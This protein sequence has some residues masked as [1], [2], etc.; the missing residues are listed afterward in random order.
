MSAEEE[1]VS[2]L[3]GM[4]VETLVAEFE[5]ADISGDRRLTLPELEA[6]LTKIFGQE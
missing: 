1:A 5:R 3:A 2:R 4:Q 6:M